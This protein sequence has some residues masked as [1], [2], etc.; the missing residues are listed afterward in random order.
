MNSL[1]ESLCKNILGKI[2]KEMK[3]SK[4]FMIFI[5]NKRPQS[6]DLY[7]TIK[8]RVLALSVTNYPGA[9]ISDMV[10]DAR[11]DILALEKANAYNGRRNIALCRLFPKAGGPNNS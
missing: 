1:S 2:D 3:F 4:M 9:N 8:K 7:D 6:G 10:A 5:D 11:K